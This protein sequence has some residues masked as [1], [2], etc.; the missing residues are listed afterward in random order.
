MNNMAVCSW[1]GAQGME[2]CRNQ[3][4]SVSVTGH[5]GGD[6]HNAETHPVVL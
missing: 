6:Q 1:E 5:G 3:A 2:R 4:F